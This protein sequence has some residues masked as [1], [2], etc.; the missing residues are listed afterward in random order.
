LE[1]VKYSDKALN[2]EQRLTRLIGLGV[3]V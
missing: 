3:M 2:V 1:F